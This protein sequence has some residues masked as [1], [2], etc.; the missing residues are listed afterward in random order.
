MADDKKKRPEKIITPKGVAIYPWLNKPDTKFKE[1]GEYRVKLA[2]TDDD[3]V[4]LTKKLK[5]MYDAAIKAAKA[6]PKNKN[7]KVKVQDEPWSA[8]LDDDSNETGR[9]L[10]SFKRKASGVSKKDGK[11]WSIK[12]DLFDAKGNKLAADA[13]VYGGSIIKVSFTAE[14]YDTPI[15]AGLSLRLEGAQVIKLVESQGR[16]AS[17]YGF[18]DESDDDDADTN[19][20][21]DTDGDGGD[22][23]TDSG[24]DF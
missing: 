18:S 24:D 17:A 9:I 3:A 23:D 15:G 12:P 22:D 13:Q 2:V 1:E 4:A 16:T 21:D 19:A 7:K 20:D 10:F 14:A 8:E 11:P 6:N 5:P